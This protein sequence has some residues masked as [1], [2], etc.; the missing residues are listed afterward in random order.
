[1]EEFLAIRKELVIRKKIY[2]NVILHD[3]LVFKM[4]NNKPELR[5]RVN[6]LSI[7]D[8]IEKMIDKENQYKINR[9]NK[10]E[11]LFYKTIDQDAKKKKLKR[12]DS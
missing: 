2:R 9:R 10:I 6:R 7:R 8:L 3:N 1:M 12:S 4:I 5:Y 11:E